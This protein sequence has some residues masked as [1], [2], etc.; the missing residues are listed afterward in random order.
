MLEVITYFNC[1]CYSPNDVLKKWNEWYSLKLYFINFLCF[2]LQLITT[3]KTIFEE[4]FYGSWN[5]IWMACISP[6]SA[7]VEPRAAILFRY[8]RYISQWR[9]A[10]SFEGEYTLWRHLSPA[11]HPMFQRNQR[12]YH[13]KS[14]WSS[15]FP[16]T[17]LMKVIILA[18][19][20]DFRWS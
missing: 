2:V 9:H 11:I 12:R 17:S 1:N 6:P 7:V 19:L 16:T 13:V 3:S 14:L 8:Y 15:P 10:R 18:T 20:R 5:T 4:I